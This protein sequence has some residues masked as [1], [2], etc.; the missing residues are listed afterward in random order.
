MTSRTTKLIL[1]LAPIAVL[2][3]SACDRHAPTLVD[4]SSDGNNETAMAVAVKNEAQALLQPLAPPAPGTPGGLPDEPATVEE[5]TITPESAQG[6]AQVVQGYYGLL[7]EGRFAD[8]HGLWDEASIPGK[9]APD[10]F[11]TRFAG[12]SEI[13][14]NVGAPGAVEGAAGSAYVTVPVQV[15]ARV[16]ATRKPWYALRTVTLRR[17][18]DVPGAS[19]EA[20][21]WHIEGIGVYPPVE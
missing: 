9:E 10:I 8:A 4:D 6:A 7:E 15:Y 11:A 5:E 19:D 2:S 12:F 14:A 17:V 20:R 21:A 1:M 13:H 3:L 18:N 16:K